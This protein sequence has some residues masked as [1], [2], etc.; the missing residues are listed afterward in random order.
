MKLRV[1]SC[2]RQVSNNVPSYAGLELL[3]GRISRELQFFGSRLSLVATL[4]ASAATKTHC[5]KENGYYVNA[6]QL[7]EFPGGWSSS[8]TRFIAFNGLQ[9]FGSTLPVAQIN[10]LKD[11]LL[12]D[13]NWISVG[14][15]G[16]YWAWT[17]V[18]LDYVI[19]SWPVGT[20]VA[21]LG[22][23][24]LTYEKPLFT[25]NDSTQVSKLKR[26]LSLP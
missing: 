22:E 12:A 1:A 21:I 23:S 17:I 7:S 13:D 5:L 26:Y 14:S 19:A 6:N 15:Y 10:A 3:I 9:K 18:N 20:K 2:K 4:A 11:E 24:T 8:N 25:I 16:I